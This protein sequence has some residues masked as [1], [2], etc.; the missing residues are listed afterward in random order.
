MSNYVTLF[1]GSYGLQ[2]I[3]MLRSLLKHDSEARV[4]VLCLDRL[5]ED[6]LQA[7]H[8]D[9]VKALPLPNYEDDS[10]REVKATRSKGEYAW[11]LTPFVF[12]FVFRSEPQVQE[13]VYL[14][15][16]VFFLKDPS[17]LLRGFLGNK[18]SS[19][20][21][22]RHG[23]VPRYDRSAT[24]GEFC[25]QF[26]GVKR[27]ANDSIIQKWRGQCLDWCYARIEEGRFGDQKYLDAW[28]SEF[29]D[30]VDILQNQSAAQGPWNAEAHAVGQASFY[31]FHGLRFRRVGKRLIPIMRGRYL[32]PP[33]HFNTL[34]R[35]YVREIRFIWEVEKIDQ[36]A[37]LSIANLS[38]RDFFGW[39][40]YV[41]QM[42]RSML[43]R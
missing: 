12:D 4:W 2:G 17:P 32:I 34:Y 22:T 3:A 42:F 8:L 18:K 10:L 23:Y 1:D 33:R 16:D 27:T 38:A 26:I 36:K 41:L 30:S 21:I 14:D 29:G 40:N 20:F 15:A 37:S 7:F 43:L 24:H 35:R 31:H 19:V 28:P 5:A 6:L 13:V 39:G 9:R 25:V 11:T